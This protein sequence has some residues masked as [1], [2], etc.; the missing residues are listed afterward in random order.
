MGLQVSRQELKNKCSECS[1]LRLQFANSKNKFLFVSRC[2][3]DCSTVPQRSQ[4]RRGACLPAGRYRR[5]AR[6]L[7]TGRT[8]KCFKKLFLLY[9]LLLFPSI[10]GLRTTS[11]NSRPALYQCVCGAFYAP[12]ELYA[13]THC[14]CG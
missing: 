12:S 14:C 7:S 13:H 6:R 2:V 1:I 4:R 11:Q 3:R 8:P 9:Q 5:K 10:S